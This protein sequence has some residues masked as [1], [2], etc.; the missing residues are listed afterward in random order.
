MQEN[1]ETLSNIKTD[2]N[3]SII[4]Y[5]IMEKHLSQITSENEINISICSN[6]TYTERGTGNRY[7]EFEKQTKSSVSQQNR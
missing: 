2:Y 6:I 7:T 5:S 3:N 1:L 4:H